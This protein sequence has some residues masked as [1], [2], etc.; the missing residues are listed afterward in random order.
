MSR[1]GRYGFDHPRTAK[2]DTPDSDHGNEHA[3]EEQL[4]S[5]QEN[6]NQDDGYDGDDTEQ[7]WKLPVRA[8]SKR[9]HDSPRTRGKTQRS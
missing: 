1:I 6:G 4:N 8:P 5:K 7:D 9:S 2:H 3:S